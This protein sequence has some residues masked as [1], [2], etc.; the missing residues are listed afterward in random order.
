MTAAELQRYLADN[1]DIPNAMAL[2]KEGYLSQLNVAYLWEPLSETLYVNLA[3][4][5]YRVV[6]LETVRT[7]NWRLDAFNAGQV[8]GLLDQYQSHF[9]KMA[10]F[11]GITG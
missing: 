9:S 11:F 4:G 3:D 2:A 7:T 1:A 5:T 6:S 10:A 8:H